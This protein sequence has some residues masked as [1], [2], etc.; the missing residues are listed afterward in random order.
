MDIGWPSSSIGAASRCRIYTKLYIYRTG[1]D[2]DILWLSSSI[3][4]ASCTAFVLSTGE[5]EQAEEEEKEEG[6][7]D[8]GKSYNLHT[9]GAEKG[10]PQPE[11]RPMEY[12]LEFV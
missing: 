10:L 5:E 2:A 1:G 3:G 7:W 9:D 12:D 8:G 4:A 6:R 11:L